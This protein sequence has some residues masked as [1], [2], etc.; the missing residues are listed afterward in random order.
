MK[1]LRKVEQEPWHLIRA[2]GPPPSWR[3]Y[4]P[5]VRLGGRVPFGLVHPSCAVLDRNGSADGGDHQADR[6]GGGEQRSISGDED[7]ASC[8]STCY[9]NRAN[10]SGSAV[11]QRQAQRSDQHW[12]GSSGLQ[13]GPSPDCQGEG[14]GF[15][16]RR[17]L[18]V[19]VH[20]RH[21]GPG[22]EGGSSA[23]RVCTTSASHPGA[24]PI[25]AGHRSSAAVYRGIASATWE[26][27]WREPT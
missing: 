9:S 5:R 8:Y 21:A 4:G 18:Q 2:D 25:D 15:E 1:Q 27:A 26:A 20:G 12:S 3:R 23:V 10:S 17:P 19:K 7:E 13:R 24:V 6:L 16:S 11:L 14:R 22:R